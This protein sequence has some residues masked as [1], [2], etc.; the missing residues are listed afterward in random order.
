MPEAPQR[1]VAARAEANSSPADAASRK[2]RLI[3]AR[4]MMAKAKQQGAANKRS[5]AQIA[6]LLDVD[7]R[8]LDGPAETTPARGRALEVTL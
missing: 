5:A 4:W 3:V 2:E 6:A 1:P 8:D 7:P